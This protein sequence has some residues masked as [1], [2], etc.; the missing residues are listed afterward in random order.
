MF[1]N[2]TEWI[3]ADFHLHTKAD[4]EFSYSGENDRFISDYVKKLK[5]EGI[6]L[7]IITNHNK[8]DLEE[9]KGLKK[10]AKKENITILPGVELSV[11]EGANGIHCLI[12]FK[13][14]D[15]INGKSE[16]INQFVDE[17]F[18]GIDNRENENTRCNKDLAGTIESLNTY[19]KDYF[20][21]MAHIEQKSGFEAECNGGLIESLSTNGW[22]KDKVYGFQKGRTRD[23]MKQLEKW[24]GYKI[25][26]IEGSDCKSIDQ[27][28]KGNKSYIK[29]GDGNFDS[30]VL[31]FQ[32]YQ[33]R[34]SLS[35]REYIHGYIKSVEFIGG[36]MDNQKLDLSP[37]LNSLIG[38]RGSGK[39]SII[40]AIRYTLDMSPSK[41]DADYKSEVVKN[42]LESGGQ[43]IIELQDNFKKNYKIKRILG[44]PPR[45]LDEND[46]D[47]E[48]TINSI[49]QTPLYFGQKDLSYMDNGFELRLLDK[50][51]GKKTKSFQGSLSTINE[52]LCN[53]I[54]Q[55]FKVN[56]EVNTL[57]DLKSNLKDIRHK[58]KIFEEKGL[59]SKLSKQ[60][61][62]QKDESNIKNIHELINSFKDNAKEL[63]DSSSL[64]ELIELSNLE[65]KEVPE[66]FIK[67][68]QEVSAIINIK[69]E[70][71]EIIANIDNRSKLV[72]GYLTEIRVTINS[73]EEEFAEIKRE[74]D[75][76]NLNPDD[77][78][79]FKDTEDKLNKSIDKVNKQEENKDKIYSQI[80]AVLDKRNQ[81]LLDE[82]NVYKDEIEKIN[83]NQNSLELSI[84]FK[85]NKEFFLEKLK[86]SFKGSNI[87]QIAYKNICEKHSDF[88][89]L[90]AD[91]LLDDAKITSIL[92]TD[93]QLSKVKERIK[94]NYNEL[95]E[96]R[97]PNQIEIKYHGKSITKHSIGQRASALV[98]FILSQKDNN[99]IMID[100]PEDDLDNQVIYNEI[101]TK[102]KKRKPGVQFIFATHNANI[103]VLGD[104]E[105][106]IAVS[107]D[108]K[109]ITVESGSVDNKDI[110]NKIV[111]IMEG[112]Q[113][114]FN[115]RT[116]IYNLWKSE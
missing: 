13:E 22:F 36:K 23:K 98:L 100:Q 75:I 89:S 24:M 46:K 60:V 59:D 79:K 54:N 77:F 93:A 82:F 103:P 18:K 83:V 65:S 2:G 29:I 48:I 94:D 67:L 104:S 55:L 106:V 20:I 85:G 12:V 51:V 88:A 86:E 107:Y 39:S 52:Q 30:V 87:N 1:K 43:V 26:Y 91:I 19:N 114:A 58:I 112:G 3:R 32:D 28:G 27:I 69:K 70:I 108:E 45:I 21:L 37:E 33:N 99:L 81:L 57:P 14:E 109:L 101:I 63:L 49:L 92:I 8:F 74:I 7:G 62:F 110:Q 44:E 76:P 66:L 40:E 35:E 17:V 64:S 96:V 50:L 95:L 25:P 116:K 10:K 41:A 5:A 115:K 31:A 71:Q 56:D 78:A 16:N 38:I 73:L 68:S 90:I 34:I 15:W 11:K 4:K 113:E 97:T 9:Y 102:V 61:T 80:R 47:I 111:D 42:L 6:K 72:K 53:H 105:Q 84:E